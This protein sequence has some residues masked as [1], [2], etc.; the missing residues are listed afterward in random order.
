MPDAVETVLA[1][2]AKD[3]ETA[4]HAMYRREVGPS[5]AKVRTEHFVNDA[6]ERLAAFV[7]STPGR[8]SS[9]PI[10]RFSAVVAPNP[11]PA[12]GGTAQWSADEAAAV[13][14]CVMGWLPMGSAKSATPESKC[15]A[16]GKDLIPTW[17]EREA[18]RNA[19]R[20]V[21]VG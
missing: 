4:V 6:V 3:V 17:G 16:P 7:K 9:S 5:T 18:A 13:T 12:E 14:K 1:K 2:L 19:I 20:R 15:M 8:A 21:A 10:Q 11:T